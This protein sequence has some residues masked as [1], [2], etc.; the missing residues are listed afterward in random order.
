[1]L[2]LLGGRRAPTAALTASDIVFPSVSSISSS[3]VFTASTFKVTCTWTAFTT[4]C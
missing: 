1:M 3:D 2:A 4:S